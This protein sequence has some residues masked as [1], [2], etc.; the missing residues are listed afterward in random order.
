[1]NQFYVYLH[2]KK[3]DNR[4]FY[5][6]KGTKD[7]AWVL[8]GRNEYWQRVADKHGV[9]VE[10][11]FDN[12]SESEALQCEKDAIQELRYFGY[13]LCNLTDGGDGCT[14]FVWS[15]ESKKKI[16]DLFTGRKLSEKH[17]QKLRD[18]NVGKKQTK[19]IINKR[20]KTFN[21]RMVS[22]DKNIYVFFSENDVFVGTRKELS[23]YTKI[24]TTKFIKLFKTNPN[25]SCF[26]WS[27]LKQ[28]ELIIIKE[29]IKWQ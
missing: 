15:E 6:G 4:V 12:L 8:R 22:K 5:V 11:L 19:D 7:R 1:M 9:R 17:K 10:I 29:L 21:D 18:A 24:P 26:G 20:V 23:I 25:K 14:G 16:S 27:V 13:D 2:I 3:S 28:N